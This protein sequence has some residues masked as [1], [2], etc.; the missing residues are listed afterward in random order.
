MEALPGICLFPYD[1][2][3]PIN[4]ANSEKSLLNRTCFAGL[5]DLPPKAHI[6]LK[7]CR[8]VFKPLLNLYLPR[9]K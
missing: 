4:C 2:I 9:L 1:N 8:F 6:Y 7:T 3:N 5:R